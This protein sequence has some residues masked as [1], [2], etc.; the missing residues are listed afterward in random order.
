MKYKFDNMCEINTN[1]KQIIID[2]I[3]PIDFEIFLD[4]FKSY[5]GLIIENGENKLQMIC[6]NP[7]LYSGKIDVEYWYPTM[8]AK[9]TI[10]SLIETGR[11][12]IIYL[13]KFA[14][15]ISIEKEKEDM[16][17]APKLDPNISN[18][19]L[20]RKC[21]APMKINLPENIGLEL[22]DE[23]IIPINLEKELEYSAK[24]EEI[25]ILRNEITM[26]NSEII[27]LNNRSNSLIEMITDLQNNYRSILEDNKN[28][29]NIIHDNKKRYKKQIDK[30]VEEKC[31]L[32][33]DCMQYD[34]LYHQALE[35]INRLKTEKL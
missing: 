16:F 5:Y 10:G 9:E 30:L 11:G 20:A 18:Q 17:P 31:G 34:K 29:K 14:W 6:A 33:N 15:N 19:D 24:D 1:I 25:E 32:H 8:Y 22:K 13:N 4:I 2:A 35:E 7:E 12:M 3:R 26:L 27:Q 28:L 21:W 23:T